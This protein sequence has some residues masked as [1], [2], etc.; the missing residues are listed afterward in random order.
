M[1]KKSSEKLFKITFLVSVFLFVASVGFK[2]YL[3]SSLA[4]K[5][6]ELEQAFLQRKS[7][8]EK[9]SK[10]AFEDS[11]ISSIELVEAK[12]KEMG[13]VEMTDRLL[14][15]NPEASIQVA[16]LTQR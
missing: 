13:F 10:L 7:L 8:E 5:N 2:L 6:S 11:N 1:I 14:S 16:V 15:I 12:A 9:I 4:V 3:C